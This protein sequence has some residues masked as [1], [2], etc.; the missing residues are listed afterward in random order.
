VAPLAARAD[1]PTA[2]LALVAPDLAIYRTLPLIRS[3]E[4]RAYFTIAQTSGCVL[5]SD[6][7]L[8]VPFRLQLAL[9]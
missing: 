4:G 7:I 2:A 9:A 5:R 3:A 6:E 1:A 8:S